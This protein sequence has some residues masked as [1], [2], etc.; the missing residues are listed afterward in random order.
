MIIHIACHTISIELFEKRLVDKNIE[1]LVIK[2]IPS[3]VEDF[4]KHSKDQSVKGSTL[5]RTFKERFQR[6]ISNYIENEKLDDQILI[7][8]GPNLYCDRESYIYDDK[9]FDFP[10]GMFSLEADYK[11]YIKEDPNHI[12]RRSYE[13]EY[14]NY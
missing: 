3:L 11:F 9:K 14:E 10:K 1:Y 8:I 5:N 4:L 7:F 12:I 13:K 2:T 6:Y